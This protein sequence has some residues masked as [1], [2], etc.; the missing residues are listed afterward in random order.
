MMGANYGYQMIWLIIPI[1][2]MG[3]TFMLTCYRISM[4]TGMPTIHAIRQLLRNTGST[5]HRS[6]DVFIMLLLHDGEHH[7]FRNRPKSHNRHK[8]ENR[9]YL[10]DSDHSCVLFR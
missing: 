9:L 2:I 1:I 6:S 3:I 10:H 4:L 7:R 5:H 8:L